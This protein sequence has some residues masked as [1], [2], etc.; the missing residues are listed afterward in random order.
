MEID[1]QEALR[2]LG[3]GNAQ[4]DSQTLTLLKWAMA[5]IQTKATPGHVYKKMN[6]SVSGNTVQLGPLE[7]AS[8]NLAKNLETCREA[9]LFS[10]TL[11]PIPDMLQQRYAHLD[12]SRAVLLQAVAAAAIEGYCN[13]CQEEIS[14]KLLK[15]QGLRPRF[16]PGYGDFS[17][18]HQPKI[19]SLLDA[20]RKIGLTVTDSFM[21]AP[22][23]SVTAVI[24]ITE[25]PEATVL[26]GCETCNKTDCNYR[27][28]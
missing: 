19:L 23:K 26:K 8:K 18:S 20:H 4:A 27:R 12:M 22:T 6:C 3:L 11:G 7:I 9:Y 2:Y 28:S 25:K 24:G 16:S 1:C 21:L 5:E 15:N 17:L 14:K 13:Q 10:A